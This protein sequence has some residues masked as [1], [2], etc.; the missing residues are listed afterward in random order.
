MQLR[1]SEGT[2]Q[3]SFLQ[4]IQ[5]FVRQAISFIDL[6]PNQETKISLIKT[7]QA[8]TEGKV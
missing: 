2:Q 6:A 7:L 1:A 8:V 5:A 3:V 4:A